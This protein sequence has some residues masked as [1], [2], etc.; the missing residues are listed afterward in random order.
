MSNKESDFHKVS[1]FLKTLDEGEFRYL[2]MTVGM[3]SVIKG[4]IRDYKLPK[5]EFCERLGIKTSQYDDY[6]KGSRNYDVK[7]MARVNRLSY[8]LRSDALAKDAPIKVAK[9]KC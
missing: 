7:D 6:I 8:E 2:E 5:E 4:I 3:A 9:L 1:K